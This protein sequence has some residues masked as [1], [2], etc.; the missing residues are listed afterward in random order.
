MLYL[1]AIQALGTVPVDMS[2][3]VDFLAGG[4]HKA[5]MAPEGAGFLVVGDAA[6]THWIPRL[7]GWLGLPQP[8][9]FLLAG[10]P[11]LNPNLKSPRSNDPTTLEGGSQN[12]LGYAGLSAALDHLEGH[13][14]ETVVQHVQRLHD[15]LE[16]RIAELGFESLRS[17]DQAC[18]SSILSFAPPAGL[19]LPKFQGLLSQAGVEISIPRGHVRFGLHFANTEADVARAIEV[20]GARLKLALQ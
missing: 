6:R 8:V 19:N 16:P 10:D 5:L 14:I 17:A 15:L 18:R 4:S 1:D 3:G 13:G 11:G 7:T 20:I 12:A 9:D 2:F